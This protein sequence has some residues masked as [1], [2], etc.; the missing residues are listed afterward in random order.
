MGD[1]SDYAYDPEELVREMVGD[2]RVVREAAHKAARDAHE[3]VRSRAERHER[4]RSTSK[5]RKSVA[6]RERIMAAAREIM[7]ERGSRGFQM[8]EVSERCDMS[9][10]ALYYYFADRD[11]LLEAI[12]SEILDE[13]VDAL[14]ALV[15]GATTARQA[16]RLL[17][18]EIGR[19]LEA[20]SPLALALSNEMAASHSDLLKVATVRFGRIIELL[21]GQFELAKSE[22]LIRDDVDTMLAGTFVVGGF[23]MASFA[24][25]SPG[26]ETTPATMTDALV[27]LS[28]R[29]I[30]VDGAI[31]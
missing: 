11:E 14:E 23:L 7:V 3:A 5:T 18:D 20:G 29:G 31:L 25:L 15:T 27:E 26:F 21:A 8:S 24:A 1:A 28:L 17:C 13:T 16:I 6:T 9:K 30:G 10:G 19:R 22:G 12:F 4:K 2:V